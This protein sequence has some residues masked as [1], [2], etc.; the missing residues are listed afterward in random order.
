MEY[1]IWCTLYNLY[2]ETMLLHI[3]RAFILS[4]VTIFQKKMNRVENLIALRKKAMGSNTFTPIDQRHPPV[5]TDEGR[6]ICTENKVIWA[7]SVAS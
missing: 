1:A 2:A 7:I 5:M 6:L 4:S 3:P